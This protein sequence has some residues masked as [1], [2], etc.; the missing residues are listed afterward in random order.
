MKAV[1]KL[2]PIHNAQLLSYLKLGGYKVGL[3][4][5]F[6]VP[7]LKEGS[8]ESSIACSWACICFTAEDAGAAEATLTAGAFGKHLAVEALRGLRVLCGKEPQLG[9]SPVTARK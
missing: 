3:L 1:G 5:N 8:A 2:A 7:R 9:Y 4:L 6:N